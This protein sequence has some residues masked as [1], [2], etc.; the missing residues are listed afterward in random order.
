[1]A[2]YEAMMRRCAA[3]QREEASMEGRKCNL[4]PVDDTL[5]DSLEM[6]LFWAIV[7]GKSELILELINSGVSLNYCFSVHRHLNWESV[8]P[9]HVATEAQNLEILTL[10]LQHGADPNSNLGSHGTPLHYAIRVKSF[11]IVSLLLQWNSDIEAP[12]FFDLTPLS[13]AIYTNQPKIV[14]F[15]LNAGADLMEALTT[16]IN[17]GNREIITQ[18]IKYVALNK[19][20]KF[21]QH[22][23]QKS[24]IKAIV[25]GEYEKVAIF[26]EHGADIFEQNDRGDPK[27]LMMLSHSDTSSII[28]GLKLRARYQGNV[29]LI[30]EAYLPHEIVECVLKYIFPYYTEEELEQLIPYE[31]TT[32]KQFSD[33][34]SYDNFIQDNPIAKTIDYSSIWK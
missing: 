25:N 21:W 1:V 19:N 5:A 15:L 22:F 11:K 8:T 14:Q 27:L 20:L 34:Q 17:H 16:L 3:S 10:L 13:L 9:L 30:L 23:L 32:N 7:N 4:I 6:G 28:Y 33:S 12:D 29:A 18:I 31:Y 24:L 26:I 2:E